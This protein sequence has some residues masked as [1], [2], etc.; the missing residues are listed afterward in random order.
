[1]ATE[2]K[3]YYWIKLS[4]DFFRDKLIKRLRKISGGDTFTI[5]YLKMLVLATETEGKLYYDG[6]EDDFCSELAL[7]IDEDVDNVR[8]T[9]NY[10]MG[11]GILVSNTQEEYELVTVKEMTGKE[12]DSARRMRKLRS[13]TSQCDAL[14]S[15]CDTDVQKS[16]TETETQTQTSESDP[17]RERQTDGNGPTLSEVKAYALLTNS[18]VEPERFITYNRARGWRTKEGPIADWKALFDSWGL[19]EQGKRE[20]GTGNTFYDNILQNQGKLNQEPVYVD[21]SDDDSP[22]PIMKQNEKV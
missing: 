7:D 14:P 19:N 10:L 4:S 8:V 18:Q 6:L 21:I 20:K 17:L 3:H 2:Q 11:H 16:D 22:F 5:I 1:M 13:K 15:Q 9:V 12:T